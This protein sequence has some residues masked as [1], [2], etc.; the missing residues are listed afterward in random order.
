MKPWSLG[1]S[2]L[3]KVIRDSNGQ[4]LVEYGLVLILIAVVVILAVAVVGVKT[5]NMYSNVATTLPQPP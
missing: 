1:N 4:T 5:S 2:W 3:K